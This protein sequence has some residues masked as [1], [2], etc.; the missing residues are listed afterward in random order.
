M[1]STSIIICAMIP[2][3]VPN[4]PAPAIG[5]T[6]IIMP[7]QAAMPK[8]MPLTSAVPPGIRP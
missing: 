3:A 1:C 8:T 6:M 4:S 7:S 5:M 2:K